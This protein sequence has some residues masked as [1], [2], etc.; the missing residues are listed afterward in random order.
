MFQLWSNEQSM[1]LDTLKK[2]SNLLYSNFGKQCEL[3]NVIVHI[4]V[5]NC[6]SM[7]EKKALVDSGSNCD[8]ISK[9]LIKEHKITTFQDD[10]I[11]IIQANG[12]SLLSNQRTMMTIRFSSEI[13][14]QR[15]FRIIDSYPELILGMCWLTDFDPIFSWKERSIL[16]NINNSDFVKLNVLENNEKCIFNATS[17]ISENDDNNENAIS[18]NNNKRA[19]E[20]IN[21]ISDTSIKSILQKFSDTFPSEL[22]TFY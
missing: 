20:F 4:L 13:V 21:E 10:P 3:I 11:N 15:K 22:F 5:P 12:T 9:T 8:F 6:S 17:Q 2:Q 1:E 16:L 18:L 19:F 14:V 7:L